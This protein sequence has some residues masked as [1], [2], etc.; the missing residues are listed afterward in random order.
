MLEGKTDCG[1]RSSRGTPANRIHNHQ[2]GPALWSEELFHLFG[3]PCFFNAVLREIAPH[4]SD[5]WFGV[6]HD[7]ILP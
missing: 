2:H 4:R 5:E 7:V 6:R 3:S 1:T